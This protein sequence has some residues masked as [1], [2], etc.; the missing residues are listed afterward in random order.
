MRN[1]FKSNPE[2]EMIAFKQFIR[3]MIKNIYSK[4]D[5]T[6]NLRYLESRAKEISINPHRMRAAMYNNNVSSI[7]FS[8]YFY[9]LLCLSGEV[10]VTLRADNEV[11]SFIM[12]HKELSSKKISLKDNALREKLTLTLKNKVKSIMV[13]NMFDLIDVFSLMGV[14]NI[15]EYKRLEDLYIR[16]DFNLLTDMLDILGVNDLDIKFE[17]DLLTTK[18]LLSGKLRQM[19]NIEKKLED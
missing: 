15:T 17:R 1:R 18:D 11:C 6:Y 3:K 16:N 8:S 7:G 9:C 14:N 10:E 4:M 12:G 19:V 13:S 5:K 2:V